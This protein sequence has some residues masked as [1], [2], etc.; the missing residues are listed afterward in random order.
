MLLPD[1][2]ELTD[3][4]RITQLIGQELIK[5]ATDPSGW[6]VLYR[7]PR[8]SRLWSSATP[9]A[10]CTAEDHLN[11]HAS[12]PKPLKPPSVHSA[13]DQACQGVF[14]SRLRFAGCPSA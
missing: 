9:K 4:A 13:A 6:R 11:S 8:D 10:N 2:T 12:R 5:I 3:A 7:D 1:E 14:A